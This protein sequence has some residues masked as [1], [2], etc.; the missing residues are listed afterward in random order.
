MLQYGKKGFERTFAR[1]EKEF[2]GKWKSSA[3]V[4]GDTSLMR[5]CVRVTIIS[6]PRGVVIRR[7]P[8]FK[9]FEEWI[10]LSYDAKLEVRVRGKELK[11]LRELCRELGMRE[12]DLVRNSINFWLAYEYLRDERVSKL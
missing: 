10:K 11:I 4:L 12:G 5:K 3:A 2:F 8:N 6:Y 7:F 9:E 1:K